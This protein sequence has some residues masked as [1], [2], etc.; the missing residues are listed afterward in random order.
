MLSPKML[1]AI[2][3]SNEDHNLGSGVEVH[4]HGKPSIWRSR[5]LARIALFSLMS[6]ISFS[7][8]R[9]HSSLS[10]VRWIRSG[11]YI[12]E[13]HIFENML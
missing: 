7:I 12:V 6:C 1:K 13:C 9:E 2:E 8:P 3:V 5:T 10:L 11:F 4:R